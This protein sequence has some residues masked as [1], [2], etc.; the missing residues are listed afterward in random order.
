L[1]LALKDSG[2]RRHSAMIP[3]SQPLWAVTG[4]AR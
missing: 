1:R 4:E 2:S 3:E